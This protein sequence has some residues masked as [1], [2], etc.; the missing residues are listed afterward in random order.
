MSPYEGPPADAL[1]DDLEAINAIQRREQQRNRETIAD[2]AYLSE[3]EAMRVTEAR[4]TKSVNAVA[5]SELVR[6]HAR[7][8]W[9]WWRRVMLLARNPVIQRLLRW[10]WP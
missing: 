3:L 5:L 10:R 1:A 7:R 9:P 6:S 4:V 2:L 8:R